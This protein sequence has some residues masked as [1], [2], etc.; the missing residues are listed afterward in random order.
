M[1]KRQVTKVRIEVEFPLPVGLRPTWAVEAVKN[2]LSNQPAAAVKPFFPG[3]S[4]RLVG[5]E[6]IYL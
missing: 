4:V 6:T 2:I 5:K 3:L 1:T